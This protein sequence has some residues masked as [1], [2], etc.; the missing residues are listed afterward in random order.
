MARKRARPTSEILLD[1]VM[2]LGLPP[3]SVPV[4]AL[5][6]HLGLPEFGGFVEDAVVF[7]SGLAIAN[8]SLIANH[9]PR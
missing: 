3:R 4:E 2:R 1:A 9:A 6:L 7:G 5:Q 8:P